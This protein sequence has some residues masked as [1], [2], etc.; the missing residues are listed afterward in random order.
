MVVVRGQEA[1][2]RTLH[3]VSERRATLEQRWSGSQWPVRGGFP[4]RR[5]EPPADPQIFGGYRWLGTIPVPERRNLIRKGGIFRTTS[6]A[7]SMMASH[8]LALS[9]TLLVIA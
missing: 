3:P 7:G 4:G 6:V 9:R 2:L 1:C 5:V 8:G